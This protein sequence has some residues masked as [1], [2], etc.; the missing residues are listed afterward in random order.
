[1]V[2]VLSIL[3]LIL[4]AISNGIAGPLAKSQIVGSDENYKVDVI[5]DTDG[6]R[7]MLVKSDTAIST[8]LA[9]LQEFNQNQTLPNPT[10]YTIYQTTG[11]KTLSGFALEFDSDEIYVKL[12][13]DGVQLFEIYC[14]RLKDTLD[15]DKGSLPPIYVSWNS[16]LKTFYFAPSFPIKSATSIKILARSPSNKKYRS[17]IIQVS[18]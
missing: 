12:E 15:W 13:V 18:N 6:K 7:K 2:K 9:I 17:S 16:G 5:L 4:S 3:L 8:D 10:F 1:M 11:I 14:K